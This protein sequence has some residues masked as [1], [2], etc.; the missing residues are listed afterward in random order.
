VNTV[1]TVFAVSFVA[2][3]VAHYIGDFWVQTDRQACTKGEPGWRGRI[4]CASHVAT[5]TATAI[6]VLTATYWKTNLHP[7]VGNVTAGLAVSAVTHYIA[8]RRTPLRRI[9]DTLGSGKF[10]RVN[11]NGICGAYLLDQAWHVGF[12]FVAALIIA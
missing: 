1:A 9:A 3:F 4:A 11:T 7:S 12:L 6:A 8:D 10:Y 5:Y 2:L